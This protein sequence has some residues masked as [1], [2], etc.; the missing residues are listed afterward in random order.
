M[1]PAA[2]ASAVTHLGQAVS[3]GIH[4]VGGLQLQLANLQ[5]ERVCSRGE[6]KTTPSFPPVTSKEDTSI[7]FLLLNHPLTDWLCILSLGARLSRTLG[8]R[9]RLE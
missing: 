1:I 2:R 4:P 8:V 7:L 5:H 6:I 3:A 9:S